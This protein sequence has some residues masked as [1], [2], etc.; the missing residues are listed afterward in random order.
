MEVGEEKGGKAGAGGKIAEAEKLK[1]ERETAADK[2][3]QRLKWKNAR[4]KIKHFQ[5]PQSLRARKDA[6]L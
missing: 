4:K 2:Q 6:R 1:E 3:Q 5:T